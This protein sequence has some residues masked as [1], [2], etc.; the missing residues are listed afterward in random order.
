MICFDWFFPESARVLAL[1][2]A[3][4]ICHPVNFVL[5]WGQRAMAITSIQNRVF[6]VTANRYGTEERGKHSFTFTGASQIV[7]P[8][9]N[10]VSSAPVEED[11]VRVVKIDPSLALDKKINKRNDIFKNRRPEF[12]GGLM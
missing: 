2:G 3:Q 5:P 6:T 12:Y 9:G 7:T 10:I 4:I 8:R 1:A 11:A